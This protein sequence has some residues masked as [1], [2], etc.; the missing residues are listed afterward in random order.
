M[1]P[2]SEAVTESDTGVA[3]GIGVAFRP[4]ITSE[5][6]GATL[7]TVIVRFSV[8]AWASLSVAV[9]LIS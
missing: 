7:T 4:A 1:S 9:T 6:V 3:S 2:K 8:V 5:T